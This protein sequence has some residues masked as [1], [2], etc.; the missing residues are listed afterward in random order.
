MPLNVHPAHN[1]VNNVP[2]FCINNPIA[3]PATLQ[4]TCITLHA[5]KLV[6]K[7]SIQMKILY[8]VSP[9]MLSALSALERSGFSVVLASLDTTCIWLN[10]NKHVQKTITK[11]HLLPSVIHA[12]LPALHATIKPIVLLAI[13]HSSF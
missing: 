11:T 5:Y 12:T 9:A 6:R 2:N 1:L 10:A 4:P 13:A 8:P 3:L 7:A